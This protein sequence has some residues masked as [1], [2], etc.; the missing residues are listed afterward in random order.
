MKYRGP[1]GMP[2]MLGIGPLQHLDTPED[3]DNEEE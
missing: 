2:R 1:L 3:S